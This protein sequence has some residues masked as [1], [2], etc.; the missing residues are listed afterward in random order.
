V[1]TFSDRIEDLN[2]INMNLETPF[3]LLK[4]RFWDKEVFLMKISRFAPLCV[5]NRDTSVLLLIGPIGC[6]IGADLDTI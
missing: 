1:K 4:P 6:W 3:E 2:I 5:A